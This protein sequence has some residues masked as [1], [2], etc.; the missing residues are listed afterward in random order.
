MYRIL[1]VIYPIIKGHHNVLQRTSQDFEK[2][3]AWWSGLKAEQQKEVKSYLDSNIQDRRA[4]KSFIKRLRQKDEEQFP[5]R[6]FDELQKVKVSKLEQAVQQMKDG[7]YHP[8]SDPYEIFNREWKDW[9]EDIPR[10]IE[11]A[12]RRFRKRELEFQ[13]GLYDETHRSIPRWMSLQSKYNPGK[14]LR[15]NA[16][17]QMLHKD[18][19]LSLQLERMGQGTLAA[20]SRAAFLPSWLAPQYFSWGLYARPK[21]VRKEMG[22]WEDSHPKDV[23]RDED[24]YWDGLQAARKLEMTIMLV[25][26]SKMPVEEASQIFKSQMLKNASALIGGDLKPYDRACI[27]QFIQSFNPKLMASYGLTQGGGLPWRRTE[28]FKPGVHFV[29]S[30]APTGGLVAEIITP[31]RI[32]DR[33][34][35]PLANIKSNLAYFAAM[36]LFFGPKPLVIDQNGRDKV[37]NG[38]LWSAHG[39]SHDAKLRGSLVPI[40]KLPN[41]H[42]VVNKVPAPLKIWRPTPSVFQ[43][44]DFSKAGD[45]LLDAVETAIHGGGNMAFLQDLDYES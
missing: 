32:K 22:H 19:E 25:T 39:L 27:S 33:K 1:R 38:L 3:Q 11:E 45:L 9:E 16:F 23:L 37:G 7:A 28:Y 15:Q 18:E 35:I 26:G 43:Y 20:P 40:E 31:D 29:F 4:R 10:S 24:F 14:M 17:K 42:L 13:S 2:I 5:Y 8:E 34:T 12:R 21:Q 6:F 41:G 36:S 30:P 44:D